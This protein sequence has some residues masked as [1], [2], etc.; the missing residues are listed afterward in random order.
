M[1]RVR[2]ARQGV[3]SR[4]AFRL[5]RQRSALRQQNVQPMRKRPSR[6]LRSWLD[7]VIYCLCFVFALRFT[8]A[9]CTTSVVE[10]CTGGPAHPG[11]PHKANKS[12][13]DQ[14]IVRFISSSFALSLPLSAAPCAGTEEQRVQRQAHHAAPL[15]QP[16]AAERAAHA[17]E[18]H[19]PGVVPSGQHAAGHLPPLAGEQ[20]PQLPR[21][22]QQRHLPA[23]AVQ[24]RARQ[25]VPDAR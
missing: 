22:R 21:E 13:V 16:S 7:L 11:T 10:W 24:L 9:T 6:K 12:H 2:S 15:P 17:P 18:R 19:L 4:T 25:S 3:I 14:F 8:V 20:L 5:R 23:L 1:Y